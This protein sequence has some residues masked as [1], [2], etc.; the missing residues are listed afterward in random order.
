MNPTTLYR[1]YF[2][3]SKIFLYPLLDIKRGTSVVP[4]Q[5]YIAWDNYYK[6]EDMKLI[7]TYHVRTDQEFIQFDKNILLKHHRLT[8]Y[9]II[10]DETVLYTFDFSDMVHDWKLLLQGSYSKMNKKTKLQIRNFF[11]KDSGNYMYVDS[12]LFPDRYFEVYS[13]LLGTTEEQLRAV[14]ELCSPPDFD[15]E[16]LLVVPENLEK[17]KILK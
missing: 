8:D 3:K 2:Q 9:V 11:E 4:I 15:K 14:G 17:T 7:A 12:Y 16:T 10:D 13:E 5:T 6:P 1:K